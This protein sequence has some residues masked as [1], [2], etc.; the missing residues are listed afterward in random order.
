MSHASLN[1]YLIEWNV[2]NSA[3]ITY[4]RHNPKT[5]SPTNDYCNN[6]NSIIVYY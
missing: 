1:R 6:K 5:N 4:K 2:F 3:Q